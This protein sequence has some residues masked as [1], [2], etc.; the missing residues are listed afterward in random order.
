[1]A[2]MKSKPD[3]HFKYMSH[4]DAGGL[5]KFEGAHSIYSH[6]DE[7]SAAHVGPVL[8]A[9]DMRAGCYRICLECALPLRSFEPGK[10]GECRCLPHEDTQEDWL[11]LGGLEALFILGLVT[12][13]VAAI[14]WFWL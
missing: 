4:A 2:L 5:F 10:G 1:M 3:G 13:C 12:A 11:E 9:S 7:D 6:Y 14:F 8:P